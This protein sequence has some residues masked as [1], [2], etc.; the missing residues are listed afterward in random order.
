[1]PD[2]SGWD[3]FTS[4]CPSCTKWPP[5]SLP[6]GSQAN[7]SLLLVGG[8]EAL[9][10]GAFAHN[11]RSIRPLHRSVAQTWCPLLSG[12]TTGLY[13]AAGVAP[14]ELS[15][16]AN[17]LV[18]STSSQFGW[19]LS[20]F[21]KKRKGVE[22]EEGD[23]DLPH[24]GK[25]LRKAP[26][27]RPCDAEDAMGVSS[28]SDESDGV[29]S[30]PCTQ[31]PKKV[32][33][34]RQ[35]DKRRAKLPPKDTP[36][37]L[38]GKSEAVH[39]G[40]KHRL[41]D[42]RS[43]NSELLVGHCTL[44]EG[45]DSILLPAECAYLADVKN[46]ASKLKLLLAGDGQVWIHQVCLNRI[47][48]KGSLQQAL[49][50][51]NEMRSNAEVQQGTHAH[52][53]PADVQATT[54]AAQQH[55]ETTGDNGG[56]GALP[57]P[58]AI[59]ATSRDEEGEDVQ[60]SMSRRDV[61]AGQ[62]TETSASAKSRSK[63]SSIGQCVHPNTCVVCKKTGGKICIIQAESVAQAVVHAT[64]FHVKQ[65]EEHTPYWNSA[66]S[67]NATYIQAD[68]GETGQPSQND[69]A[70]YTSSI[71]AKDVPLHQAC[72]E[73]FCVAALPPEPKTSDVQHASGI[74]A[75]CKLIRRTQSANSASGVLGLVSDT[76]DAY[77]KASGRKTIE[78]KSAY[79][80]DLLNHYNKT[81]GTDDD[82]LILRSADGGVT[83]GY[84]YLTKTT[85]AHAVEDLYKARKSLDDANAGL[86]AMAE[87]KFAVSTPTEEQC[88]NTTITLMRK[89]LSE[90][91]NHDGV[92][93]PR[94]MTKEEGIRCGG[95]QLV[96]NFFRRLLAPKQTGNELDD[97]ETTA[98]SRSSEQAMDLL[99]R[100]AIQ[101]AQDVSYAFGNDTIK[102]QGIALAL[103]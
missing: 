17:V 32:K 95:G 56:G 86:H 67:M 103:R 2:F 51:C 58:S 91:D 75:A 85:E 94:G 1:M 38:C 72:R 26:R 66:M 90:V 59:S 88:V 68:F 81:A 6:F 76:Y 97:T 29:D 89:A 12:L 10:L 18:M 79:R 4:M 14:F 36:C 22:R 63:R 15:P 78:N 49:H 40:D 5:L 64:L 77:W 101:V 20:F 62:T 16:W 70:Q 42:V 37:S 44:W 54:I 73:A 60:S 19:N 96:F 83:H 61:H 47:R 71:L 82:K 102:H 99:E 34:T 92:V 41:T 87:S 30:S 27:E 45:V 80:T 98:E 50:Y 84:Y 3:L 39:S 11:K 9:V 46:D 74:D 25:R 24:H 28:C 35:S 23:S 52:L 48:H 100:R 13:C 53:S 21:G 55:N 69:I 65:G 8:T 31:S 33:K 7:A 57:T 43:L 93:L